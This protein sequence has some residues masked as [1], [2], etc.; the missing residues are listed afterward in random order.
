MSYIL[1]PDKYHKPLHYENVFTLQKYMTYWTWIIT[2]KGTLRYTHLLNSSSMY[3]PNRELLWFRS[4]DALPEENEE[5]QVKTMVNMH[6]SLQLNF[7]SQQKCTQRTEILPKASRKGLESSIFCSILAPISLQ[8]K[9]KILNLQT[10][11]K[12]EIKINHELFPWGSRS[13]LVVSQRI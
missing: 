11:I 3:F 4:V 1:I 7:F 5:S 9:A 10:K 13:I 8:L 6:Y 12:F 2:H